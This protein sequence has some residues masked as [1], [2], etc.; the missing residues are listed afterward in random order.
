MAQKPTYEELEQKIR[1]LEREFIE[2]KH[3]EEA[4]KSGRDK[5][6][7]LLDGLAAANIGV[8]IISLDYEVLQQNQTLIDRFGNIVGKKCYH[9]YMGFE[10]PCEFC[11]MARAL[12]NNSI[13]R[14]EL[15]GNDGR[16]YEILSAPLTNADGTVDRAIEVVIDITD[17][18]QS[19]KRYRIL[20]DDA[21]DTILTVRGSDLT[22]MDFNKKSLETFKCEGKDFKGKTPFEISPPKQNDGKNS[23]EKAFEIMS[24]LLEQ[25]QPV[26]FEWQHKRFTGEV[27]D[28]EVSLSILEHEPEI[29]LQAIVRDIT[30]RKQV[31]EKLQKSE[32][33]YREIYNASSD[34]I[35][36]H[37]TKTGKIVDVNQTMLEMF[38][39]TRQEALQLEI[40]DISS[41][42]PQFI[43]IEAMK[44]IRKVVNEGPQMFE[45]FSRHKNGSCFWTEVALRKTQIGGKG[46]VLA[47]VRN[48]T[49]RKQL[50]SE[51]RLVKHSIEHSAYPF[52]WIQKDARFVYVN[53][54]SCRALGYTH[55][56][57]C[58]MRVSDIDPDFPSED[59][60]GFWKKL[61]TEKTLTFESYHRKK[62]GDIFPV[63]I[64]A[65]HVVFEGREHVFAYA[66]DISEERKYENDRKKLETQLLQAQKMESIGTLAGGIAHD[67]N[68][69]LSP[70]IGNTELAIMD[71]DNNNPIKLNLDEIMKAGLRAK[72]LVQQIL[73]FS[74]Q[75]E[76]QKAPVQMGLMIKEI[77]KLLRS[78]IP[79]TID[80]SYDIKA[81]I[82]TVLAD[83]TQIHQVI[84]NLCTNASHSMGEKGGE[85]EIELDDLFLESNIGGKYTDLNP[86]SYLR[87]T[88]RDTGYGI[89]PEVMDK[90]F[91][92]YFTTK[93]IGIG[94]GIGLAVVHGIV[95]SLGGDINVESTPGE[96][97]SFRVL[98]PKY[99]A[100][101]L[102]EK[103]DSDLLPSGTEQILLVDDEKATV[104]VVKV[105]L[106]RLGY[107][108]TTRTSS[109]EALEAFR[110][111]PDTYDLVVTDMTMPNMTG[112]DLAKELMTIRPDIPIILCTGFSEQIDKRSAGEM[113]IKAFVMKPVV[114]RDIAD[115]IREVLDKK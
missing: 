98:F 74:R 56:E 45:W 87:L 101:V 19:E 90:I 58:S 75:R 8:D 76:Q 94:T 21:P 79:T 1:E 51:L 38:G 62:N 18:K 20:F 44:R 40:G 25:Q 24:T 26:T 13:E 73:A 57:L 32:R 100:E 96:G 55:E 22:I 53:D 33:N 68:N 85:L 3:V 67:F 107:Q 106:E 66:K 81:E 46:R 63:E 30:A 80:I 65:N 52:E 15:R 7:V 99:E 72:D 70:I 108:V 104:D 31:E 4:L 41:G 35:F 92:P 48:I 27:F 11:P 77:S 17:R 16:D 9:A 14:I 60:P 93:E 95:Q 10:K 5:L 113:G 84:M 12:D 64:L 29:I 69:I 112:K 78:S 37:D 109:I 50:D 54:A 111:Q 36:I 97:S 83:P 103:E 23:K 39:Y 49:Q 2:F 82:D 88:V 71:V 42:E 34:A 47:F 105:M 91:E 102:E 115:T 86:G 114:M 6:K 61:K 110:N 59:W 43:Q 89:K 28:A